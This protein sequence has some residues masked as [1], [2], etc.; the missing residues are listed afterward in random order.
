LAMAKR[1]RGKGKRGD[2]CG[3]ARVGDRMVVEAVEA[4]RVEVRPTWGLRAL[5][6]SMP[7]CVLI[8]TRGV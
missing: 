4:V 8:L 1:D 3:W 5:G 7:Q 2:R 6:R